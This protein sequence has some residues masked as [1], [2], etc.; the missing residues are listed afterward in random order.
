MHV[1]M[2]VFTY[3]SFDF[4]GSWHESMCLLHYT[5]G[6]VANASFL[7]SIIGVLY[8]GRDNSDNICLIA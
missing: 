3:S 5:A 7:L 1:C 8:L 4:I 6:E 2:C